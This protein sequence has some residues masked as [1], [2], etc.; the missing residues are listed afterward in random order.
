MA[1]ELVKEFTDANFDSEVLSSST[2]VL[3]DFWAEWCMPCRSLG[4][5]I[6]AIATEKGQAVKVGKVDI[7]A[8]REVTMKYGITAIPTIMI[9]KDGKPVRTFVGLHKK[10]GLV[11]ALEQAAG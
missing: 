6:D 8:N 1:N 4:P 11:A 10:E 9:F 5:I 2:P 3:V 7:D